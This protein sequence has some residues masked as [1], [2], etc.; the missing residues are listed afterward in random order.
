LIIAECA[1]EFGWT[2]EQT[3]KTNAR[4][5]FATLS[6]A[7]EL[8]VKE[9]ADFMHELCGIS[10][11]PSQRIEYMQGLQKFYKEVSDTSVPEHKKP[12]STNVMPWEAATALMKSAE[13][14]K[15]RLER[16]TR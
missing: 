7:R 13:Q 2:V 14:T 6:A 9:K 12:K 11:I 10:A 3:L 5:V 4:A 16:G 8:K 15:I 1:R